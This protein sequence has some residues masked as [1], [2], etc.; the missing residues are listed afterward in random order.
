MF[1][2][3]FLYLDYWIMFLW[4][5][6]NCFVFIA[7]HDASSR[8]TNRQLQNI[9]STLGNCSNQKELGANSERKL[10]SN[11]SDYNPDNPGPPI[12]RS[13]ASLANCQTKES[14]IANS[15]AQQRAFPIQI[16][17]NGINFNN[18]CTSYGSVFP[19]I[20]CKQSGASPIVSPSSG[21]QLEP[22]PKVNPFYPSS[23]KSSELYDHFGQTPNGS[24][25]ISLQKQDYKLESLEDRERIS[26]ATDQS[27]TSSFCNGAASHLNMGYGSTSGSNSNV[28]QVAVVR[29]V[30]ERKS[31]GVL[32]NVNS[33]RSIQREAA[34]SK[35]RLKRKDRCYEKKVH[36]FIFI[37][38]SSSF[39]NYHSHKFVIIIIIIQLILY[40]SFFWG[41]NY[42]HHMASWV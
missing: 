6:S 32:Q 20:F 29:A 7:F 17:V 3:F 13:I 9:H 12:E 23:F 33:H 10:S 22:N 27:A 34:L 31:E 1:V 36:L 24:T 30:A 26:P 11:V 15:C 28:D 37:L 41:H 21:S 4:I 38:L 14:E 2:K 18:L 5:I 8:Y 19:P 16:P 42:H 35:F 40:L 25:N 39:H